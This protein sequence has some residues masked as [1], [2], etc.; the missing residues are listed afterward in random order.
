MGDTFLNGGVRFEKE[1]Y[2][3]DIAA[4]PLSAF[5]DEQIEGNGWENRDPQQSMLPAVSAGTSIFD[6]KVDFQVAWSKTVARPTFWEFIPSQSV[7]QASGL[8]RRGNNE[9]GQTDIDNFD[10]AMTWK[11]SDTTSIRASLF[12]KNLVRPLV[13]FYENGT[14]LYDDSF[15]DPDTGEQRDFNGSI[16][17]IEFEA[18]ISD[19][20]P[21]SLRGNF[22]YIDAQLN[23]F[24]V[25]NGATTSVTS[26]LPY[27]PTYLTN[28]NLGYEYEPW[29]FNANFVYNYNGDYPV[30]LKLTPDDF[31]VTRNAIHTFDLVLSKKIELNGVDYLLKG[32]VKNMFNATDTYLYNEKVYN[33]DTTGRS[34][35][36]EIQLS[37]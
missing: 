22:T 26:K 21:F 25:Q 4:S 30:I 9:L 33:S 35:W 12:H 29:N 17:G 31:E 8:G 28:L 13:T 15:R 14:L 27:Q 2:D 18:D 32:G 7:D 16:N 11:P 24:Y 36:A 1:T 5:T 6:K 37:F 23:Y 19:M 20:G 3:I 34:Y 10:F